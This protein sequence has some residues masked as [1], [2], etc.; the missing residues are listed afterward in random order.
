MITIIIT[1]QEIR[2]WLWNI[3]PRLVKPF[4]GVFICQ[5]AAQV[6]RCSDTAKEG[7]LFFQKCD[8]PGST[9]LLKVY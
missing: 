6:Q 2:Y 4:H 9:K 8:V 5:C 7:E 3:L 1:T